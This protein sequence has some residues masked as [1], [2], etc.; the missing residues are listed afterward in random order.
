MLTEQYP[1]QRFGEVVIG[2]FL[3]GAVFDD[4]LLLLNV[5]SDEKTT[6]VNVTVFFPHEY[7]PFLYSSM[8]FWLSL[9]KIFLFTL[10]PRTPR[11]RKAQRTPG[12]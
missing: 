5:V 6:H 11:K 7:L 4:D 12:I 1:L 10:K 3:C 2:N 9:Y 8:V